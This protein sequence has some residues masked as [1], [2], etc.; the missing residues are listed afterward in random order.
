MWG[1][2]GRRVRARVPICA[3][4]PAH[5]KGRYMAGAAAFLENVTALE[6]TTGA[7]TFAGAVPDTGGRSVGYRL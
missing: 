7:V 6:T 5:G 4:R 1:W 3:C 2:E